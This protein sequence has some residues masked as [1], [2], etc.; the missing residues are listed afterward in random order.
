MIVGT[1]IIHDGSGATPYFTPQFPRGGLA[2]LFSFDI[3]HKGGS[4]TLSIVIEHKN[5]EDTSW[6]TLASITG[7]TATG[8]QTKDATAI[9]EEL[10]ISF[11]YTAG[12]AGDFFH[13]VIAAPAWRPYA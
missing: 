4:P 7:L 2:A 9:K 12:S 13:I 11:V 6:T 1:T 10:R 5:S 3:T 8:V